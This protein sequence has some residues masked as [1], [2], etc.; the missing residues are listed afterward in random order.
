MEVSR[1]P[2]EE[3]SGR[4]HRT[5]RVEDSRRR[6]SA[7]TG[8]DA[9]TPAPEQPRTLHQLAPE[10]L[11]ENMLDAFALHSI[12]LDDSGQPVDYVFLEAN[13]AF[14]D[15]TGLRRDQILG[16]RVTEVLPGIETSDFDWI[17][18]YGRVALTGVGIEF[19]QYAQPLDRWYQVRAY[20]PER[21]YFATLFE[22]VT[23]R[24]SA[25]ADRERLL[26]EVGEARKRAEVLAT[27]A[28][29]LN[30]A[31]GLS[32][33]LGI[34][35][36]RAVELLRGDDG[37]LFMF[38]EDGRHLR[39]VLELWAGDRK[40]AVVD[41][42]AWPHG[43][44]A[45]ETGRAV[46]V[47]LP[48]AQETESWWFTHLGIWGA[49]A[50]PL[51][52]EDR[53]LGLI[54]VNFREEG[55]SPLPEDLDFAEAVAR[56]CA[57]AIDRLN[58]ESRLQKLMQEL[59]GAN[60]LLLA[61]ILRERELAEAARR[62][63]AEMEAAVES[64]QAQLALL[65]PDFRFLM[66]NSAYVKGSGHTRTA[67]IGRNHFDLFPHA[68]N[69]AIFQRVRDT[70]KP[71]RATEKPFE[72]VDQ[73]DRGVTY[74]NWIL[75]PIKDATGR[76]EGLLLSLLDVTPQ[77]EARLQVEALAGEAQRRAEELAAAMERQRDLLR[78]VSHDLRSPLTGIQGHAQLLQSGLIRAGAEARMI[79]SAE[80]IVS[81]TRRIDAMLRDLVDS[82]RF[83]AGQ[84]RL[85][86]QPI[87]L[88]PFLAE[89]LARNFGG[90]QSQRLRLEVEGGIH[91]VEA[92][93]SA[94]ERIVANL[95]VNALK[96]SRPEAEV[97]VK[98]ARTGAE[99]VISVVDRGP[100]IPAD[101][102]SK[103]FERFY[104]AR[105]STRLDGLGLGLYISRMLVEAHGGR[106]WADSEL[107]VGSTFSFSLPDV[108][109]S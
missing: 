16:K 23:Q 49:I 15:L 4:A 88:G 105:G 70:G 31:R 6:Q 1:V 95:L 73:P 53:T 46:Y 101:E 43:R 45:A 37:S 47:T 12:L 72:Y 26:R 57:L 89:L 52:V 51:V 64:T 78:A 32:D 109:G 76:V 42:S 60:Q 102:L 8:P 50:A 65:D 25:D 19:E 103:V 85:E 106:I 18:T 59:Q 77:V 67:L 39:G 108:T 100:G 30:G 68:E 66:V 33:V 97:F 82:A 56:Q 7:D 28:S 86:K 104:R 35:L 2:G 69:Q 20:S 58:A 92:D 38:E 62:K 63:A 71:Y 41:I 84:L 80:M 44:L 9:I 96:Y 14:E 98:V 83:E 24:R 54:V 81:G 22:D 55:Y 61:S 36:N 93:H 79:R 27:V 21:G 91:Q 87:E 17:G 74:W 10:K 75:A 94:L 11:F 99:T 3:T 40:G 34:A 29:E 90:E 107:G 13:R 5:R 48:E